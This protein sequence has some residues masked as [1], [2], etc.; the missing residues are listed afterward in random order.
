MRRRSLSQVRFERGHARQRLWPLAAGLLVT[1]LLVAGLILWENKEPADGVLAPP[2]HYEL[3]ENAWVDRGY[4]GQPVSGLGRDS[5][6]LTEILRRRPALAPLVERGRGLVFLHEGRWMRVPREGAPAETRP[7]DGPVMF[8]F[9]E[10][11]TGMERGR[12]A[13]NDGD[14]T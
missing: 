11:A 6:E 13:E 3:Q 12:D 5:E 7:A 10:D 4:H 14:S 1:T 9:V 8:W 2:A